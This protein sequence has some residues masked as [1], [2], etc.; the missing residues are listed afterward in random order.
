[1]QDEQKILEVLEQ[2]LVR[3]YLMEGGEFQSI[4]NLHELFLTLLVK[5]ESADVAVLPL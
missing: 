1:M 5:N 2:T 4:Y 3:N